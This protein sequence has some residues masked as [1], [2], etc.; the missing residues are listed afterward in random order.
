MLIIATLVSISLSL[1][2]A[3]PETA[4]ARSNHVHFTTTELP[5]RDERPMTHSAMPD[6]S[7]WALIDATLTGSTDPDARMEQLRKALEP[8]STDDLIAY[9][10]AFREKLNKAYTWDLW[11]A[12]Y[13]VHGGASDDGF[14]YFRRWL[15]MRGKATYEA[16]LADPSHLATIPLAPTGPEGVWE[17]EEIY[18]VAG[19]L[20][21]ERGGEDDIRDFGPDEIG[22]GGE[23][24][25]GTPFPEEPSAL[26]EMY[27]ALW[28]AFGNN[29][30]PR[31]F[32]LGLGSR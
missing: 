21:E 24:P 7:F 3:M 20:F 22:L 17:F 28:S 11:A 14:E 16:A 5:Q 15:V 19:E 13:I 8:L 29:P 6:A 4:Q 27:P 25:A 30:L 2:A 32:S 31:G 1:S 26:Q 9:E 10:I 18:Y 12:A 23:E